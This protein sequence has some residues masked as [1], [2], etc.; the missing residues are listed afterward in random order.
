MSQMV[1]ILIGSIFGEDVLMLL[2]TNFH[3]PRGNLIR[4]LRNNYPT[5]TIRVDMPQSKLRLVPNENSLFWI[6]A[7][8]NTYSIG[9]YIR[10]Y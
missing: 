10:I 2:R 7:I 5:S 9:S 1:C 3:F 6:V 8:I 4:V